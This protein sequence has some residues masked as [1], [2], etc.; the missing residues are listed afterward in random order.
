MPSGNA[1]AIIPTMRAA[2]ILL[3]A[4]LGCT[5]SKPATTTP[6]QAMKEHLERGDAAQREG[7]IDAALREYRYVY[8]IAPDSEPGAKSRDAIVAIELARIAQGEHITLPQPPSEPLPAAAHPETLLQ[9]D[10]RTGARV[11]VFVKGLSSHLA[12]LDAGASV[13]LAVLPGPTDVGIRADDPSALPF[14]GRHLYNVGA[15]HRIS[16]GPSPSP[17]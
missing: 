13:T 16:V 3:L 15:L 9:I 2:T 6:A 7:Q 12:D 5:S 8:Q 14:L 4:L 11:Y 1:A 17:R 10:N